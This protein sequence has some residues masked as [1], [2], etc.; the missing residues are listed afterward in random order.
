MTK[1][2]WRLSA[3]ILIS[4]SNLVMNSFLEPLTPDP[5]CKLADNPLPDSLRLTVSGKAVLFNLGKDPPRL[6]FLQA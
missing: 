4:V 3:V 1:I 6:A 2:S 5:S